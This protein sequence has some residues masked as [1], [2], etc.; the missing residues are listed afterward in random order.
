MTGFL[1]GTLVLLDVGLLVCFFFLNRRQE[2]HIELIEELSEERR[3]LTD[4]RASVQEELEAADKKAR[5]SLNQVTRIAAEAEH[6][7][8]NGGAS[9][10]S[11]LEGVV[12]HL[13]ER[14]ES[15]LKDLA[16]KTGYMENL[17]RKVD[18]EKRVLKN[19]LGRSEEI[20]KFFDDK[21]P[22]EQVIDEIEN[23][24]YTD[25][26]ALLAKGLPVSDVSIELN[27]SISEVKAVAGLG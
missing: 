11:E 27:M 19:L 5:E 26:R 13:T 3:L 1:L 15:P 23:K 18:T 6:E 12:G 20:I 24:K 14:F 25:A 4:L 7:V 22:Y 9:I 16:K 17:L 10:A 21:V 2:A 8:K